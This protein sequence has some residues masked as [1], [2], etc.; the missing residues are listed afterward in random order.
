M[1]SNIL[2][3]FSTDCWLWKHIVLS[4]ASSYRSSCSA[5]NKSSLATLN[6]LSASSRFPFIENFTLLDY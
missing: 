4:T 6:Q 5:A 2:I 1:N 3:Y